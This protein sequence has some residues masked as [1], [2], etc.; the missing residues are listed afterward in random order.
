MDCVVR[1]ATCYRL[2]LYHELCMS[3]KEA[4][5]CMSP[6]AP[7]ENTDGPWRSA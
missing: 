4:D 5:F 7:I 2:V 1:C 3:Q 6:P